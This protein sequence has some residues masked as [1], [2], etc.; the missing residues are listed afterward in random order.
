LT[1]ATGQNGKTVRI[2]AQ[3]GARI[4]IKI[5]VKIAIKI[6]IVIRTAGTIEALIV[7]KIVAQT[8]IKTGNKIAISIEAAAA[9]RAVSV[10]NVQCLLLHHPLCRLWP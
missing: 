5:V 8:A 6:G 3:T 1:G 7:I 9:N 10:M 4:V 2:S